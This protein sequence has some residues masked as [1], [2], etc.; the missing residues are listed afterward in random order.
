LQI[1]LREVRRGHHVDIDIGRVLQEQDQLDEPSGWH[2][3]RVEG[4]RALDEV[5]DEASAAG[6]RAQQIGI[7]R[8]SLVSHNSSGELSRIQP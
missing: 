3:G 8:T 6:Q 2:L 1:A 7:I 4:K 5:Q